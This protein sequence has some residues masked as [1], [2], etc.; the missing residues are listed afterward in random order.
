VSDAW[1]TAFLDAHRAELIAFRR[2]L[3]AHPELSYQERATTDLIAQRL[4]VAGLEP[5]L[6]PNECGLLCD[7]GSGEGPV[8]G[9]RADIDALAMDD[10]KDVPYRS[11]RPGVAHTCGHDVHA[12]IVLGAGLALAERLQAAGKGRVRLIF[13]PAEESLPGG[14]VEVIDAGGLQD[15]AAI[16]GLHCDPKIDVGRIAVREGPLTSATDMVLIDLHGPGGHTARPHLTVDLVREASRVALA[17]PELVGKR[18][19]DLGDVLLVFGALRAGDAVNVIPSHAELRGTFRTPFREAW[20]AAE[21]AVVA[22]LVELLADT[23]A[24]WHLDYRRGIPPVVNT[25]VETERVA[26]AARAV[27]GAGGVIEAPQSLGG[28]SFAWYL[29]MIPGSYA[30]LGVHDPSATGER[31]DLHSSTFDIDERAIDVGVELLVRTALSEL[32]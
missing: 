20:D 2:Q 15:V 22:A 12:T 13:E 24:E 25:R 26:A 3:H 18:L 27:V 8:V 21:D 5:V 11:Q 31:H 9:L 14:A 28:D 19:A 32:G 17:L 10:E 6:L 7:I 29:E 16:Y 30:R 4:Q 23:G 1:L